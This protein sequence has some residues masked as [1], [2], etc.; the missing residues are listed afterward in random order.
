M[1][2]LPAQSHGFQT[3]AAILR[4]DGIVAYPTE[5]VY[6]LAVNPFSEAALERLLDA[7]G[8]DASKGILLIVADSNQL[9]RVARRV[10]PEAARLIDAFW[11]GPLTLLFP[12]RAEV[13]ELLLGSSGKVAV[14]C[15]GH[16]TAR[17]LCA[18]FG[19]PL[20][21]TSANRAGAAPATSIEAIDVPGVGAV[22]NGGMLSAAQPSTLLD[23]E[24][25]TILRE[26]AIDRHA[27]APFLK[28]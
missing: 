23:P 19:G 27:L 12:A 10:A 9:G 11:P 14:R 13:P 2:I 17:E 28:G 18:V 24:T 15:P 6:G 20:T 7:K 4:Q 3:A 16:A 25:G 1:K 22:V 5:T 8:R 26:G 21:S